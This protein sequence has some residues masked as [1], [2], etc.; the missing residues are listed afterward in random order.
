MREQENA[1][2]DAGA[3]DQSGTLRPDLSSLS[4]P[5]LG[6]GQGD[7]PQGPKDEESLTPADSPT[8]PPR[9]I[10]NPGLSFSSESAPAPGAELPGAM[11]AEP[12]GPASVDVGRIRLTDDDAVTEDPLVSNCPYCGQGDQRIGTRCQRCSQVIVRLPAW[13]QHRRHNWLMARLSWKRIIFAAIVAH[14]LVFVIWV[15]YPF[16]PNPIV[17]LKKIQSQITADMGPGVWTVSGR[18]LR[19]TRSVEIGFPPPEGEVVWESFIPQPLESEP[20]AQYSSLFVGSANGVYKLSE[21]DGQILEGWDGDTPGR[22]T[23]AAAVFESYLFFG[24]TD[25]TVNAWNALTGDA[26]WSF[27]TEDTVEISPVVSDGLVYIGSGKGLLYA[28]DAHN[29]SV[30]WQTRLDSDASASVAIYEGRLF[31]GDD[32]GIFYIL[33][34]RTGQ[35]WFRYRTLKTI[36]GSPVISSDGKRAYFPSSGELYAV[37]AEEREVPGLYQF[38]KIWAQLWLWQVPGVPRPPGQQGGLWRFR[39]DNPLQGIYSAPALAEDEEGSALY[40]GGYDH[41]MYALDAFDGG[42]LWTFNAT[43]SI[44]ASPMIVKDRLIFGDD[45]GNVYS[46]DRNDGSLDWKISV[47]S[48]VTIPPIQSNELVIVRTEDGYI[49]G[50]K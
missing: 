14:F 48:A 18:D 33:S 11:V 16:A 8:T 21:N 2:S 34:A 49:Y 39:P 17:L 10:E 46:L 43:D 12:V 26:W 1:P 19:N 47:G 45:A 4:N 23:G 38:K 41:N 40:V 44:S 3:L 29:G 5:P 37:S 32:K 22:I 13:A 7:L 42:R 6:V 30:I 50:I 27:P 28:L 24:S 20:V 36:A 31:V 25:H 15:N 35:E 9:A